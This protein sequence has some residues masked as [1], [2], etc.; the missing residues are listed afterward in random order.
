MSDSINEQVSDGIWNYTGGDV[1]RIKDIG[2][3]GVS[4]V[5]M[6]V[7]SFKINDVNYN[8]SEGAGS[9]FQDVTLN[10]S[11]SNPNYINDIMWGGSTN[12]PIR[13]FTFLGQSNQDGRALINT[14]P[15]YLTYSSNVDWL[16]NSS[17]ITL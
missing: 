2:K 3:R 6:I 4:Y 13:V 12:L 5:D 15:K 8:L 9:F 16:G 17:T 14:V 1:F 10:T 7:D 11:S